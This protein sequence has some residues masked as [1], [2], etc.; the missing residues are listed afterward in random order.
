[1]TAP[2]EVFRLISLRGPDRTFTL[3]PAA[4]VK[5]SADLA[6]VRRVGA[7]WHRAAELKREA[8]TLKYLTLPQLKSQVPW[9]HQAADFPKHPSFD[10]AECSIDVSG[11]DVDVKAYAATDAFTSSYAA[12]TLSWLAL[13]LR[14]R[15]G[16]SESES[17]AL[18]DEHEKALR[19]ADLIRRNGVGAYD[20]SDG[21]RSSAVRL[22]VPRA[23]LEPEPVTIAGAQTRSAA[24]GALAQAVPPVQGLSAI[25]AP[26]WRRFRGPARRPNVSASAGATAPASDAGAPASQLFVSATPAPTLPALKSDR[27]AVVSEYRALQEIIVAAALLADASNLDGNERMPFDANFLEALTRRLSPESGAVLTSFIAGHS[28][29]THVDDLTAGASA[30]AGVKMVTANDLCK[31]IRVFE[32][33][34]AEQLPPARMAT[35]P[36]RPAIRALGWGDLFVVREELVGYEA[37]EISHI[38]NVLA[39]E[40]AAREHEMKH[41]TISVTEFE[42]S[43]DT[44]T[45]RD[46]QTTDRFEIQTE[47]AKTISTD[48]AVQAGV[49]TSGK[50]GLT[51]VNTSV[52]AELGRSSEESA[53]SAMTT[54]HEVV[55]KTIHRTQEARTAP[56][57]HHRLD[58]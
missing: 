58:P 24:A 48:F 46:L 18:I 32:E 30:D 43:T 33:E 36:E 19:F 14:Q 22:V 23:W 16:L 37:R 9:L 29:F 31:K 25:A 15:A 47:A 45:E 5:K 8:S 56:T 13:K 54:A 10:P 27:A 39:G 20:I 35:G 26:R 57:D 2:R 11:K 1:M 55:E 49:N 21:P 28:A 41:K 38:E 52:A 3:D 53:R 4:Y 12:L 42:T 7:F 17:A 44:T 40:S 51:N 50:Y 6:E 34:L